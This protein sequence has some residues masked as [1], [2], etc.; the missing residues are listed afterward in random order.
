MPTP[1]GRNDPLALWHRQP[2]NSLPTVDE[3]S[4]RQ[5]LDR[6]RV[7]DVGRSALRCTAL[8]LTDG[9]ELSRL[10]DAQLNDYLFAALMA[11]RLRPAAE[12]P[13]V[14][15]QLTQTAQ[16]A[17]APRLTPAASSPRAPTAE[18]STPAAESTFEPN[19]DAGA[20]IAVLKQAAR[21]GV[22]FCEEC[23][24]STAKRSLAE[25]PG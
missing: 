20:Q 10:D 12:A 22:P 7:D 18:T 13:V 6:Q 21:D 15:R 19:L 17:A 24:K 25:A 1:T 23:A 2:G 4:S 11:G 16:P 9:T 14:L 3:T 5:W 8:G